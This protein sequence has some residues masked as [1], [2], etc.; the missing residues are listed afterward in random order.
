MDIL[1]GIFFLAIWI[2]GISAVFRAISSWTKATVKTVT[3]GGSLVDNVK[4]EYREMGVF[5]VDVSPTQVELGGRM[6]DAFEVKVRGLIKAPHL[7]DLALVTSVFDNTSGE[8]KAVMSSL[9]FFQEKTTGGFQ[10]VID[11]GQI[12]PNEGYR[13]WIKV[14]ILYPENLTGTYKG[15]RKLKIYVRA[16]SPDQIPL[17]EWGFGEEGMITFSLAAKEI[18]IELTEKGWIESEE[19][20]ELAKQL[21]VKIAVSVACVDGEMNPAEGKIIQSWI[22]SQLRGLSDSKM[23][24]VKSDLNGSLKEAF[25]AF[26]SSSLNQDILVSELKNLG[27]HSM[28]QSL[29]EL[30]VA[31]IGADDEITQDEMALVKKIGL[32]LDVDYDDIK[33]MSDKAFL[34]MGSVPQSENELEALLGIDP[35]WDS[36]KIVAHLRGEFSKWNGRIQALE[37]HAEKEKAQKMIDAIAAARQKYGA[38]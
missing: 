14:A 33:A 19:E 37:D 3:K 29:L 8:L 28:N 10:N 22:K 15:K 6:I 35:E 26:Q 25:A 23:E 13:N 36:S 31:V 38:K 7:S 1:I 2:F 34:E 11:A 32:E 17:I 24:K 12:K 30:L 18:E 27:L 16:M 9:D 5:E 21:M 4:E 20:R